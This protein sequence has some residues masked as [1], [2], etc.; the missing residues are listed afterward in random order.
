HKIHDTASLAREERIWG[1][2]ESQGALLLHSGKRAV[3]LTG[4]SRLKEIEPYAK[5]PARRLHFSH[6]DLTDWVVWI[7]EDGHPCDLWDGL[8]E[9]LDPFSAES[10]SDPQCCP[11]DVGAR[12]S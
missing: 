6:K 9:Q 5:R 1:Y 3:K 10:L 2:N 12:P 11:R 4:I 8:L 7:P